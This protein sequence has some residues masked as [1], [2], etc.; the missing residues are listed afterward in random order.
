M[1]LRQTWLLLRAGQKIRIHTLVPLPHIDFE[2][3]KHSRRVQTQLRGEQL[4]FSI[5]CDSFCWDEP[6]VYRLILF[7]HFCHHR[8]GPNCAGY[9][10]DKCGV[11]DA[12][13]LD[14]VSWF[15]L[16][17]EDSI[18]YWTYQC[19]WHLFR[20][21]E[22]TKTRINVLLCFGMLFYVFLSIRLVPLRRDVLFSSRSV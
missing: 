5:S 13:I 20:C 11:E 17:D 6:R 16:I 12:R 21:V 14:S 4:A 7:S 1:C 3:W 2:A 19:T 18:K 22:G 8:R 15:Y 9:H 10:F